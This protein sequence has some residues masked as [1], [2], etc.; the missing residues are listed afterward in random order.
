MKF[1]RDL[2][3]GASSMGQYSTEVYDRLGGL[4]AILEAL[5][6]AIY[7]TDAEGRI[8][9]FN[10]EAVRFS[11]R[12]PQLG[13]DSWCVTS[14]LYWP[15]G[16]PLPHDQC[17]M[18]VAL[19]EG[20]PV[21]GVSAIAERPDGTR[22][23]FMPYPT[24]IRD[25]SGKVIGAVNMLV[26]I[27]EQKRAEEAQA[28]LA[29][30]VASSVDAIFSTSL[31]GAIQTWNS[32]AEYLFGYSAAE[33][34]GQP[35]AIIVPEDRV[36]EEAELSARIARGEVVVNFE[37]VRRAKDG[38]RFE[39]SLTA[40]PV[41]NAAGRV[42]GASRIPRDISERKRAEEAR[43]RLAAIVASS[44]D[45]IV[46]KSLDGII[47]TWNRGAERIFGYTAEEAT[48][49]HIALIIPEDRRAEEDMV[50]AKVRCGDTVDHFETVRRAKDGRLID[51][52]LT[53]SPIRDARGKVI[54]ASKIA[55]DI[56]ERKR[57]DAELEMMVAALR[58]A[59]T[60]KDEFIA[61][62]AHELRNPLSAIAVATD[63]LTRSTIEDRK[64][65]FAV[66]AIERQMRQLRRLVDDLLNMARITSGK[67]TL[68]KEPLELKALAERAIADYRAA[69]VA[70]GTAIVLQGA[71][72]WVDADPARLRQMIENLLDNATKYGG[73]N[74]TVTVSA[75]QHGAHLSVQDDGQGIAPEM[76]A[77]LFQPFVQ[78]AQP[79]DREQRGLGLGLALVERLASL[80]G[81]GVD[82][83]S[84]GLGKG[85]TFTISLP[86]A[87]PA[88]RDERRRT[89][90]ATKRRVLVVEDEVDSRE[91]LKLL[92]ETEGHQ[93]ALTDNGAAALEEI[94]R[95]RP[96]IA[97][98]DV[99]LPGMDGYE[100]ARR[101]RTLPGGK[102]L[103]LIAI[104]G[105]GGDKHRRRAKSAG[106]D[107]HVV[108]PISYEQLARVFNSG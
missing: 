64:A 43:S 35:V 90:I 38:R 44:D 62:L 24:P 53:V 3:F 98:V 22:V 25:T 89:P 40:S 15:D 30:I 85:S 76:Q 1:E 82:A 16:T 41:R 73:R 11:G 99:G 8:T 94:A 63:L 52:S 88:A 93:V 91:C 92:L 69:L 9:S 102:H 84:E 28:R 4:R 79:A 18:A 61:M 72:A 17:P 108:K 106:F 100:V 95:F 32:G 70:A 107:M 45:A 27:T 26:D 14:K 80:H 101:V 96:D 86:L 55:R 104:T 34:L 33:A 31:N 2:P 5:P 81:G 10:D 65:R 75:D 46:S 78:G 57:M 36:A 42:V 59:D 48:G 56:S 87:K 71:E 54:G 66:P 19:R 68:R 7:T 51:I 21:R 37:T 29:A 67:L 97:L 20:R 77:S 13:S 23:H 50:L 60:R 47:R 6:A 49:R 39:V 58:E 105:F 74:I 83:A 103:K 12:V